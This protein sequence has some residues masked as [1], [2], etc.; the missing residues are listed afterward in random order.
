MQLQITGLVKPDDSVAIVFDKTA[1]A[2]VSIQ[3]NS[4]LDSASDAAKLGIQ[5]G[6]L[7]DGTNY[8]NTMTFE[9]VSKQLKVVVVNSGYVKP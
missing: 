8:V 5:F 6:K 1:R 3:I 9:G 2:I 4:Y 7:A